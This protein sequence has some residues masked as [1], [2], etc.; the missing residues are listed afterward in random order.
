MQV[1]R[2]RADVVA[3]LIAAAF[4]VLLGRLYRIQQVLADHY[5][6]IANRQHRGVEI[7][8]P[9]RGSIFT[10]DGETLAVSQKVNSVFMDPQFTEDMMK[11]AFK[12]PA[13]FA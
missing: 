11:P 2:V 3:F 5:K 6:T 4:L 7:V 9:V 12:L 8:P 13:F 10:A 1:S